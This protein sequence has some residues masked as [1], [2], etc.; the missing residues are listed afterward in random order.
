MLKELNQVIEYI[1]EHLT[2]DITLEEIS[3]Y[4]GV[5]DYHFKV[6]TLSRQYFLNFNEPNIYI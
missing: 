6:S 5:S 4:A 3:E 2:A 1:E